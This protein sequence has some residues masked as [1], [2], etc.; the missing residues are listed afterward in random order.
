MKSLSASHIKQAIG[1]VFLLLA[2]LGSQDSYAT[3]FEN[4]DYGLI[5]TAYAPPPPVQ[6]NFFQIPLNFISC[7]VNEPCVIP[8]AAWVGWQLPSLQV[9]QPVSISTSSTAG[10][11]LG[12]SLNGKF[13]VSLTPEVTGGGELF[14]NIANRSSILSTTNAGLSTFGASS[15]NDYYLLFSGTMLGGQTY[16]LQVSQV[17]PAAIPVP[18]AVWLFGSGIIGLIGLARKSEV[19]LFNKFPCF[20]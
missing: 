14:A 16:Q 3:G 17:L 2:S 9:G 8:D 15:G 11:Y 6:I 1:A 7:L 4:G 5:M 18:A 12:N 19:K 20:Q 10:F 13:D